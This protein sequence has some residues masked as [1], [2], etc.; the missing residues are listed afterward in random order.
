[1]FI[2]PQNNQFIISLL[3]AKLLKAPRIAELKKAFL[4]AANMTAMTFYT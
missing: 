4:K 1:M 2:P 3:L